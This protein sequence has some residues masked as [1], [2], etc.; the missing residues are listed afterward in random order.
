MLDSSWRSLIPDKDCSIHNVFTLPSSRLVNPML[1]SKNKRGETAVLYVLA[2]WGGVRRHKCTSHARLFLPLS[3]LPHES[4]QE[5]NP[6]FTETI[7]ANILCFLAGTVSTQPINAL[8]LVS[9][10]HCWNR[11]RSEFFGRILREYGYNNDY[12]SCVVSAAVVRFMAVSRSN[13][14]W[15]A[16]LIFQATLVF[17][18]AGNTL[19]ILVSGRRSSKTEFFQTVANAHINNLSV[20][21]YYPLK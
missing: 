8:H 18:Q 15:I 14:E 10:A 5:V 2:R 19:I 13:K 12:I 16:S 6:H 7:E 17:A 9:L 20:R 3:A 1:S 21:A 4:L 11:P